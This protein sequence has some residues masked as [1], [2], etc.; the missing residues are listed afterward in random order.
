MRR[1]EA[2]GKA[3][4][5]PGAAGDTER[6]DCCRTEGV[7]GGVGMKAVRLGEHARLIRGITFK[8]QDKCDGCIRQLWHQWYPERS[9]M[10]DHKNIQLEQKIL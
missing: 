3:K 2:I 8:P 4:N 10:K 5:F 6:E 1:Y 9:T 7:G